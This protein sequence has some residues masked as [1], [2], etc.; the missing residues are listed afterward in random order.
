MLNMAVTSYSVLCHVY[1]GATYI[2]VIALTL[3]ISHTKTNKNIGKRNIYISMM[4]VL[5]KR[6]DVIITIGYLEKN[7]ALAEIH[8]M[9]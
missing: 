8:F 6:E 7:E 5:I 9:T 3:H 1:V 4:F 2:I